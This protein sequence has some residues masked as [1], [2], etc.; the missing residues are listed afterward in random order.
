MTQSFLNYVDHFLD[1]VACYSDLA[2]V[3]HKLGPTGPPIY[4]LRG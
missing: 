2:T 3:P 1:F 4:R